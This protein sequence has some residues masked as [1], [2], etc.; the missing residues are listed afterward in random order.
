MK[1]RK[2]D[3]YGDYVLGGRGHFLTGREAVGQAIRTRLLL[4]LGE[5]WEDPEDGLPLFEKIL[6]S[7]HG[8]D[9]SDIDL[10]ISERILGTQNVTGLAEFESKYDLSTRQYTAFCMVDTEFGTVG[11]EIGGDRMVNVKVMF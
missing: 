7:F 10:I 3:E 5:W 9:V 4:L 1:Y 8:E 6:A 11:L 2:L